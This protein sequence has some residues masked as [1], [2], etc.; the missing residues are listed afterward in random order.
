MPCWVRADNAVQIDLLVKGAKMEAPIDA[1]QLS[2]FI[3]QRHLD[4]VLSVNQVLVH[5]F[6]GYRLQTKVLKFELFSSEELAAM[7]VPIPNE[8]K[9]AVMCFV[10]SNTIIGYTR[11]GDSAVKLK[12]LP[13]GYAAR[14]PPDD[15]SGAAGCG[16]GGRPPDGDG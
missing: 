9:D 7:R 16:C 5:E 4:H 12:N 1:E 3:R 11:P 15:T 14:G 8:Y 10:A 6:Q 2:A 13:G